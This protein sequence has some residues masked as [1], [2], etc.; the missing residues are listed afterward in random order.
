MPSQSRFA[1]ISTRWDWSELIFELKLF[2]WDRRIFRE[3]CSN[4]WRL[5]TGTFSE[6]HI[7]S[8]WIEKWDKFDG[9]FKWNKFQIIWMHARIY[10]NTCKSRRLLD[11]ANLLIK[12]KE[13]PEKCFD[14][15]GMN[16]VDWDHLKYCSK[17][18]ARANGRRS[19]SKYWNNH[20]RAQPSATNDDSK[21]QACAA[22]L[23]PS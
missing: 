1:S 12:T 14:S 23:R 19:T 3:D 20:K 5:P 22:T 4:A 8:S 18:S 17:S 7:S 21:R 13:S 9:E 11:T 6:H 2:A 10:S 16:L 15:N